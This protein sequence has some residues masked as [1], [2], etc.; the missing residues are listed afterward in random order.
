MTLSRR[1]SS[2]CPDTP[3]W[4]SRA[5]ASGRASVYSLI[6]L[7]DRAGWGRTSAKRRTNS[8]ENVV[9]IAH[10]IFGEG[11]HSSRA[12]IDQLA[13]PNRGVLGL[14][15]LMLFRLQCSADRMGQ[16]H[17]L[18]TALIV[19]DDMTAKTSGLVTDLAVA[20]MR[21]ISQK[22]FALFKRRYIDTGCNLFAAVD[23]VPDDEFMGDVSSFFRAE[24]IRTAT[25]QSLKDLLLATRSMT[26]SFVV[27]Q[28]ANRLISSASAVDTMTRRA[29]GTAV[30]IATQTQR[31]ICLSSASI[32]TFDARIGEHFVDFRRG[33]PH[34][35]NMV[36]R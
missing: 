18:Q 26:K 6:L 28:L 23:S 8:P 17:N 21:S 15:D 36:W 13:S 19:R 24:S 3:R 14:Y 30:S 2:T 11:T 32:P 34:K 25:E 31:A 29:M 27:Y 20:G 35:R 22:V 12:L 33:Q 5:V 1:W 10:R 7:L 16:T 4:M 9:E